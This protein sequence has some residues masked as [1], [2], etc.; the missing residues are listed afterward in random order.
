MP[1]VRYSF[2]VVQGEE[3]NCLSHAYV[4]AQDKG[5]EKIWATTYYLNTQCAH[6]QGGN[7]MNSQMLGALVSLCFPL[8]NRIEDSYMRWRGVSIHT[9]VAIVHGHICAHRSYGLPLPSQI[10]HASHALV[11]LCLR[12]GS[13][14]TNQSSAHAHLWVCMWVKTKGNTVRV[15]SAKK[16]NI[17]HYVQLTD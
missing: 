2:Y 6:T 12:R 1:L 8:C 14:G 16:G 5:G 13:G 7:Q 9:A 4:G 10:Y 11:S 15:S 17:S 3:N